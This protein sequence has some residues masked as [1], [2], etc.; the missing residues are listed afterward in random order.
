MQKKVLFIKG[1]A[2]IGYGYLPF[3]VCELAQDFADNFILWGY[4][5]EVPEKYTLIPSDFP[6]RSEFL[7]EGI[8]SFEQLKTLPSDHRLGGKAGYSVYYPATKEILQNYNNRN[9][10]KTN[11]GV[12]Y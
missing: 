3:Q 6:Y 9:K 10:A 8:Y 5:V 2:G 12:I 11:K 1:A 4:A 7:N